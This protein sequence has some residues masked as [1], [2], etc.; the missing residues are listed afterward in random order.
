[1]KKTSIDIRH[2]MAELISARLEFNDYFVEIT[3]EQV[4]FGY[5]AQDIAYEYLYKE[6]P[7]NTL[8]WA[9]HWLD[10]DYDRIIKKYGSLQNFYDKSY[11]ESV[12]AILRKMISELKKGKYTFKPIENEQHKNN[13]NN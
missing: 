9:K 1:M 7:T 6:S 3:N 10:E 5:E 12:I 4:P 2:G 8:E 11:S 13:T